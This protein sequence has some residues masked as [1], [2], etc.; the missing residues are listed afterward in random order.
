MRTLRIAVCLIFMLAATAWAHDL[1]LRPDSLFVAPN[2][3]VRIRVLNGTFSE[4]ENSISWDRIRD[5]SVITATGVSHPDSKAWQEAGNTSMLSF[6]AREEGT[7]IVALSTRPREFRL[8][9]AQFNEYLRTDGI[10]DIL[11][12]RTRNGELDRAAR[13]RYSKHVK[14][15]LQAG[16]LRTGG[17]QTV[18]GYPAELVPLE[19]PYNLKV[20][21]ALRVRTLVQG[22]PV[23]NQY[24]LSGGLAVD[25]SLIA[26]RP[27]RSDAAGIARVP[28]TSHGH[29]YVK[30][31][32]MTPV[33]G[34][35]VDYESRWAT[36]TFDVR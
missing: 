21:S 9:A 1:F 25:G 2:S 7:Y 10:P 15:V 20:G 31:I 27:A 35:S 4:S 30:F 34:D 22:A 28:L 32:H 29:W 13:E 6:R 14:A 5:L 33:P 11:A 3:D 26:E 24:V 17:F 16:Q 18:L 23:A 8:E 12:A 19:N 36:L